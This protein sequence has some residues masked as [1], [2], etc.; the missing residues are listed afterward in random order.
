MLLIACYVIIPINKIIILV[1]VYV[2]VVE[3]FKN[4]K[5]NLKRKEEVRNRQ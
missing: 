1:S 5:S 2:S 4:T 3:L